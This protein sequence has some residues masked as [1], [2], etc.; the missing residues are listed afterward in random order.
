MLNSFNHRIWKQ[1]FLPLLVLALL[2][3]IGVIG[4]VFIDNYSILQAIYMVVVTLTTVG[5]RPVKGMSD[6]GMIF[7]IAFVMIGIVLVVVVIGRALEFIVSGEFIK[8]RRER[9]MDKKLSSLKNH[10][11]ICGYGRVGHQIAGELAAEKVPFVIIDEKPE[12]DE[13]L[14][15]GDIPH[16]IGKASSD[17]NLEKAGIKHAKGLIAANDSDNEN[18]FIT[19]TARSLNPKLFIVGR[20]SQK[21]TE[22]K[23]KRA[24][25]N[26]VISPYFIAGR[27]MASMILRPVAVDFL[28]IVMH[29]ENAELWMN[30]L[31]V[32]AKS[33]VANLT[34]REANLR[35]RTGVL[36]MT[37]KK[38]SGN[39]VLSPTAETRM[40]PGDILVAIGTTQ[41]LEKAN[42]Y[43]C[44]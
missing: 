24:G 42:K 6:M 12:T 9:R 10:Y 5:Y 3:L 1:F 21:E 44:V 40:E 43:V 37:I 23:L 7:D 34:L 22:S 19:L 28:D 20:A 17:E 39:Y 13:E 29:S 11:I 26:R 41:Q 8:I 32:C 30:E 14:K 2:C 15:D 31:P 16:I 25:A 33:P 38:E 18:V 36:V 35:K 4:F 27:R